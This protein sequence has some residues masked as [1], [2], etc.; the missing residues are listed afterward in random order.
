MVYTCC[1]P[2]SKVSQQFC[3]EQFPPDTADL[4]GI[5]AFLE[6]TPN[7]SPRSSLML[8]RFE[9]ALDNKDLFDLTDTQAVALE[10]NIL[11]FPDSD[12]PS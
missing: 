9:R 3:K 12:S 5:V 2:V 11:K 4:E 8:K 10:P 1:K 6:Q 7:R